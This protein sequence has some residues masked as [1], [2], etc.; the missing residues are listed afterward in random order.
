MMS[1]SSKTFKSQN[2]DGISLEGA[3][4]KLLEVKK[5]DLS[6][7]TLML[8]KEKEYRKALIKKTTEDHIVL[9]VPGYENRDFKLVYKDVIKLWEYTHQ[10]DDNTTDAYQADKAL[11]QA[12]LTKLKE[13]APQ[14]IN[15]LLYVRLCSLKLD[16][17][18]SA[19]PFFVFIEE[20]F[21]DLIFNRSTLFP[22]KMIAPDEQDQALISPDQSALPKEQVSLLLSPQTIFHSLNTESLLTEEEGLTGPPTTPVVHTPVNITP[23]QDYP[24]LSAA[25]AANGEAKVVAKSSA[26]LLN[27]RLSPLRLVPK[28]D[29][30][31]LPPVIS[32]PVATPSASSAMPARQACFAT[33]VPSTTR[34][35]ARAISLPPIV[36]DIEVNTLNK[37]GQ[38]KG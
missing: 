12:R 26:K 34:L 37:P 10:N 11:F 38:A 22:N 13:R 17:N 18:P 27:N 30:T 6:L 31:L 4:L 29:R 21:T 1:G 2:D 33:P 25:A 9:S 14:N 36:T 35:F 24:K 20:S 5:T 19:A 8:Q 32:T 7:P 15:V 3:M 23:V 16:P 28:A